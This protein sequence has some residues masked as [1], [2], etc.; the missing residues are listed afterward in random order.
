MK[1]EIKD[2]DGVHVTG[3]PGRSRTELTSK[4]M[5]VSE[6]DWDCSVFLK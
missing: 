1:L 3:S 5:S 6:T 2:I 4:F